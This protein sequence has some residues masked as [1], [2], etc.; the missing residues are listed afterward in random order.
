MDAI[1]G[2]SVGLDLRGN[3]REC[4]QAFTVLSEICKPM[5]LMVSKS[6]NGYRIRGVTAGLEPTN[7]WQLV[8]AY[9]GV[10]NATTLGE[11]RLHEGDRVTLIPQENDPKMNDMLATHAVELAENGYGVLIRL[12]P[13]LD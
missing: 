13:Y 10:A 3:S 9:L 5:G 8:K 7:A 2:I 4:G 11:L 12:Q 1:K 6:D